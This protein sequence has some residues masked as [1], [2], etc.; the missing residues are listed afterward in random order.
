MKQV[1]ENGDGIILLRRGYC[2]GCGNSETVQAHLRFGGIFQKKDGDFGVPVRNPGESHPT[3]GKR[4]HSWIGYATPADSIIRCSDRGADPASRPS[5][6]AIRK[7][8][9]PVITSVVF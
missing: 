2:R 4:P 9:A 6:T 7:T 1:V 3:I 5:V 8:L